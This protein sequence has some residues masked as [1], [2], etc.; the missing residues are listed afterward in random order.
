MRSSDRAEAGALY[1]DR[2]AWMA[3]IRHLFAYVRLGG[4]LDAHGPDVAADFEL[5]ATDTHVSPAA[6][7]DALPLS[8][9]DV[10]EEYRDLKGL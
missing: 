6:G 2:D 9:R 1:F 7:L 5:W 8:W 3:T 10:W 4:I